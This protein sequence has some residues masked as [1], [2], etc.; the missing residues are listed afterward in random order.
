MKKANLRVTVT[1]CVNTLIE[2]SVNDNMIEIENRVVD[3]GVRDNEEKGID[4]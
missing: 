4:D 2:C 3:A 1:Y